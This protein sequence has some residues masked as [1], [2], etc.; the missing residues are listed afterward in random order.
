M[1]KIKALICLLLGIFL[2]FLA[3]GCSPDY[4][5]AYIY[6]ELEQRP[7][8]LDPQ[9][10]STRDE[11]VIVRS[12]FD[13]LLRYDES[14]SVTLSAAESFEKQGLTYTFKINP[15][16]YW[17]EGDKL[18]AYD[19]EFG[20]K[21]ALDPET[22]APAVA[23]L[24]SVDSFKAINSETFSITLKYDDADFLKTLTL[25]ITMPCNEKFFN[26]CEGKYGLTLETTP[27]CSSY[28]IRKWPTEDKFLIRLAKNLDYKGK[29]EARNMRV[30]FTCDDRSN[31]EMLVDGDTDITFI[32]A[33]EISTVNQ[34]E[35]F[36]SSPEDTTYMLFLS[37]KL[38][39][40]IRLSL[41]KSV[42]LAP[43]IYDAFIDCVAARNIA[44]TVLN[45]VVNDF[46]AQFPYDIA[47][48]SG[49]YAS[50]V[51]QNPEL[52]LKG[53]TLKCYSNP[54]ALA[55]AKSIVAHW[56]QNL[57]AFMNIEE[58]T[59]IS[60]LDA[61]YQSDEYTAIIMPVKADFCQSSTYLSKFKCSAKTLEQLQTQ[62]GEDSVGYPLFYQNSFTA[63]SENI[64]NFNTITWLG[65]PDVA[66]AQK[67]E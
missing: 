64:K 14:G 31:A 34:N 50:S 57:G 33:S 22:S 28:Y 10:V 43:N 47:T 60:S 27:S 40:N 37:P 3:S 54:A 2:I 15:D 41:M 8:T 65:I 13:T 6:F 26:E 67:Y 38:D 45:A 24:S 5:D 56:Q 25:P 16:V 19:F 59:S 39:E 29:F 11:A 58:V 30:Y 46:A 52:S 18:T 53:L 17:K 21:R 62:L 1:Q 20:F 48:A 63:S 49:L 44:P 36:I 7:N 35:I 55:S 32:S 23:S 42:K 51:L 4:L 61:A 9:L 12:L 66:L